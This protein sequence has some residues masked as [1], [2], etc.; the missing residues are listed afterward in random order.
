MAL[1][2]RQWGIESFAD[3]ELVPGGPAEEADIPAEALFELEALLNGA[4]LVA[5]ITAEEAHQRELT[6]LRNR[7]EIRVDVIEGGGEALPRHRGKRHH[8]AES[9]DSTLRRKISE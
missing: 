2:R 4:V 6:M 9:Q 8:H 3:P 7:E 5:R 1:T